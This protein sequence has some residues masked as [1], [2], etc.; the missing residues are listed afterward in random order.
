VLYGGGVVIDDMA[1]LLHTV[2]EDANVVRAFER[3]DFDDVPGGR[4]ELPREA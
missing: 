4:R 2:N 1:E 3:E